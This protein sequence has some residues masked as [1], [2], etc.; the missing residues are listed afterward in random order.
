MNTAMHEFK[1]VIF[2]ISKPACCKKLLE[3]EKNF[4]PFFAAE[5]PS[6]ARLWKHSHLAFHRKNLEYVQLCA[7]KMA[8]IRIQ[9][10]F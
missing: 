5:L 7:S 1:R 3:S 2:K 6:G 4:R 9:Q 8:Y 10:V